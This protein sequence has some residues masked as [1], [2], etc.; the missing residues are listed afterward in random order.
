MAFVFFY[1]SCPICTTS[2]LGI[3]TVNVQD[4]ESML[5]INIYSSLLGDSNVSCHRVKGGKTYAN[6]YRSQVTRKF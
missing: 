6:R 5:G 3:W 1:D 4:I 2:E